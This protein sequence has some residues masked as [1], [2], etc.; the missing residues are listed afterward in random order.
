MA[1]K[2]KRDPEAKRE[3]LLEAA[4]AEFSENGLAGARTSAIAE[5][6]GVSK[7]LI[8]HHFGGKQGLYDALMETWLADEADFADSHLDLA[9]LTGLYVREGARHRRVHRLLLRASLAGEDR[10]EGFTERDIEEIRRRQASGEVTSE[11]DPGFLFMALRAVAS[12]S[13]LFPNDVGSLLGVDPESDE[14]VE[15]HAEQI[16]RLVELLGPD[17]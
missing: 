3:A 16:K 4:L 9:K 12:M 17:D 5:R 1:D 2:R 13:L 11:L 14:A 7:Q 15:W 10:G 8:S 6:A